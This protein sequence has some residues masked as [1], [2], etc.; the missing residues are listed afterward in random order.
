[1][2]VKYIEDIPDEDFCGK[3]HVIKK[4]INIFPR[5]CHYS[6]K[7]LFFKK[8]MKVAFPVWETLDQ[9]NLRLRHHFRYYS[10]ESY[11]WLTISI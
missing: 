11:T 3:S 2:H 4:F 10:E 1:M 5:K 9:H 7:S 6:G 8:T